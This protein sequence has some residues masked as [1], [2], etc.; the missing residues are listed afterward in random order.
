MSLPPIAFTVIYSTP[1]LF[2]FPAAFR[3]NTVNTFR[4][5][6][7]TGVKGP[8]LTLLL[9]VKGNGRK[10]IHLKRKIKK[11]KNVLSCVC[12]CVNNVISVF[13]S[14]IL[15]L[16]GKVVDGLG[17]FECGLFNHVIYLKT[18]LQKRRDTMQYIKNFKVCEVASKRMD[19]FIV[20][21][22]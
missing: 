6:G 15:F 12:V 10:L 9:N 18:V 11:K 19:Y 13:L 16:G 20:W 3:P 2:C 22:R 8:G 17:I 4:I 14:Y 5:C 7:T 21:G 1:F